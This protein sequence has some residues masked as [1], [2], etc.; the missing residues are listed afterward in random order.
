MQKSA[1]KNWKTRIAKIELFSSLFCF[2]NG[3]IAVQQFNYMICDN[4]S[5]NLQLLRI[6]IKWQ[7]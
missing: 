6:F 1:K 2:R 5:M 4:F 7:N 3:Q